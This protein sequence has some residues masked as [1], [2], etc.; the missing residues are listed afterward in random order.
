MKPLEVG[1]QA[2]VFC[3]VLLEI[4]AQFWVKNHRAEAIGSIERIYTGKCG[5]WIRIEA[6]K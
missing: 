2:S 6:G 3:K 5:T 1:C 4:L